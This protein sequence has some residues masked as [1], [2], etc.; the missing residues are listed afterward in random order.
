[1][2]V[3]SAGGIDITRRMA[4]QFASLAEWKMTVQYLQR[5]HQ[6][7]AKRC[8]TQHSTSLGEI[9]VCEQLIQHAKFAHAQ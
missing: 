7:K 9:F 2:V 4:D 8:T 5:Q 6:R 3:L 1:M